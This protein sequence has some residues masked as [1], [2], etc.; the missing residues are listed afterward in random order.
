LKSVKETTCGEEP[1]ESA[2]PV[3]TTTASA[4]HRSRATHTHTRKPMSDKTWIQARTTL[5]K[6]KSLAGKETS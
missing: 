6:T 4:V 2:K 5:H 1:R 3:P